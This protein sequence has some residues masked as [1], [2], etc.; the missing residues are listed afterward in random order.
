MND[1]VST[2]LD[3]KEEAKKDLLSLLKVNSKNSSS[4]TVDL[5]VEIIDYADVEHQTTT[6]VSK[7]INSI[8]HEKS[9]GDMQKNTNMEAAK[10]NNVT[11]TEDDSDEEEEEED[12][13]DD[14]EEEDATDDEEDDSSLEEEEEEEE[15]FFEGIDSDDEL[16]EDDMLV[17]KDYIENIELEEGEDLN[18]LL[19]WSAMQDGN[20]E[21]ELDSDDDYNENR[22]DYETLNQEPTGKKLTDFEEEE[23]NLILIEKQ[24]FK[25]VDESTRKKV[26]HTTKVDNTIVDPEIFGQTLK[27]ALADVPPGLRPGMRRW[28]EK[29]QRKE[30]RLKKKEEAKAHRKEKKKAGKGKGKEQDEEDLTNQMA[31]IDE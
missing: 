21:I 10:E 28:Y 9:I 5:P 11:T 18:D 22:Y 1:F 31:K 25:S 17:M 15:V 2:N 30:S 12:T 20:L 19:V 29:Q 4:S 7:N 26:S 6:Q 3:E 23:E 14:E 13:D 27:A 24:K 8:G 16:L